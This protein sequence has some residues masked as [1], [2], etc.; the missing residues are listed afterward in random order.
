MLRVHVRI[1]FEQGQRIIE[2]NKIERKLKLGTHGVQY[3]SQCRTSE[4]GRL[5]FSGLSAGYPMG[6]RL[7]NL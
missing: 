7:T 3:L 4:R 6:I 2:F 1:L 5:D